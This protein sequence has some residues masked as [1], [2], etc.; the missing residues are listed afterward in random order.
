MLSVMRKLIYREHP[1][2]TKLISYQDTDVHRGTI[3]KAAGWK[4]GRTTTKA[5]NWDTRPGRIVVAG[6]IKIR[7]EYDI[8]KPKT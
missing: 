5:P 7:W 8:R 1:E 4:I 3:Y 2:I 6:G